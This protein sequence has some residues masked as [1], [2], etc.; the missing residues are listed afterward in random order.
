M[1]PLRRRMIE[2]MQIRNL[3]P[4]T[5]RV[6]VE[7]VVRFARHFRKSPELLGPAEIRTYLLHLAQERRL[8]ASSIIVAVSALRFFYTVTLKRPWIVEDDIPTGRQAKKLPVVLSQDEVGA[9]PG[10][11]GQ[12]EAPRDPD[13]LLRDRPAD[14][15]SRSPQARRDRQ[16][17]HGHPGRAGQRPQRPLCHAAAQTS[18]YAQG[19]LEAYPSRRV[20]VSR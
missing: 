7:Q 1:S 9:F 12:P 10:R 11:R 13:R 8:A 15:R 4:H 14:F 17:A 19:L 18:R 2:D 5:Q 3:T 16:Q 6:Y 20:A